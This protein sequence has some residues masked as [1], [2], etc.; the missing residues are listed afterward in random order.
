MYSEGRGRQEKCST[1]PV[2][3]YIRSLWRTNSDNFVILLK[4]ISAEGGSMAVKK[5]TKTTKASVSSRTKKAVKKA[6]PKKQKELKRGARYVC[7]VCGLS[8]KVDDPCRCRDFCDI[9][10]CGE[11]MKP[12]K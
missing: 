5:V 10:C 8:M 12:A 9:I 11:Q 7:D 1:S 2:I 4:R 6:A 3:N